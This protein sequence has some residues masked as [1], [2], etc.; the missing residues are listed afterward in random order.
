M[1]QRESRVEGTKITVLLQCILKPVLPE[2]YQDKYFTYA[3]I[4]IIVIPLS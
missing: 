3:N 2:L 1:S 4:I